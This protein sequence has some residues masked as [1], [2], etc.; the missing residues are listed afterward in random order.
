MA[1]EVDMERAFKQSVILSLNAIN[2]VL[3]KL[4]G[5]LFK[6]DSK[7]AGT[8]AYQLDKVYAC[9]EFLRKEYR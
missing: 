5:E 1:K 4:N 7:L 9:V 6:S 2:E 8:N 3:V